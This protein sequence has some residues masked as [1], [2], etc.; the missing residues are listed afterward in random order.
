MI[1]RHLIWRETASRVGLDFF[2]RRFSFSG[3]RESSLKAPFSACEG[4]NQS[5][6]ESECEKTGT[7]KD[8]NADFSEKKISRKITK[9]RNDFLNRKT[10]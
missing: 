1:S 5:G 3:E 4:E 6:I 9:V 10:K 8:E 2:C 7:E